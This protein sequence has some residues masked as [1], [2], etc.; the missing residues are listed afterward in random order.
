M[1]DYERIAQVIRYLDEH[2]QTQP[3]L[4]RLAAE[5]GLGVSRFHRLFHRWAGITPKDFLQCLTVEF[6]KERL[7]QSAPILE[8]ALEVGLSGPGRLHDL[9]VTLEAA[10][11][12]EFKRRGSGLQVRWGT[13]QSPFGRCSLGWNERGI[14]HLGF[15]DGDGTDDV[16]AALDEN[17]AAAE[18]IRDDR[19]AQAQS[20]EIFRRDGE[21]SR[22][23]RA[24]VCGTTF[25]VRVWRALLR[26]PRGC[27]AS[28]RSIAHAVG[29]PEAVRAVGGACGSNPVA[30]LIP[31]HRVIRETGVVQ[32]YHWGD[33]RKHA[34]LAWESASLH[35]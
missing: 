15:D 24:F 5:A 18:L 21:Q 16:P 22:G 6:A 35:L 25:Q 12:G 29:H 32:G 19:A 10:S 30:F 3:S 34:M 27:L 20:Q 17:W 28:Y 8:A 14:C 13:A 7:R 4:Q 2:Q 9:M 33:A 11:P 26:I 31:C 1:S 23:L